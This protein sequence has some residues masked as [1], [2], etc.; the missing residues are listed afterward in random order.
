MFGE[1][2]IV[3][4]Y[5]HGAHGWTIGYATSLHAVNLAEALVAVSPQAEDGE[6]L[7]SINTDFLHCKLPAL[8]KS[9]STNPAAGIDAA[10]ANLLPSKKKLEHIGASTREPSVRSQKPATVTSDHGDA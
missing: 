5:G 10:A 3:H 4:N 6:A 2:K 9:P 7:P 1:V 8:A